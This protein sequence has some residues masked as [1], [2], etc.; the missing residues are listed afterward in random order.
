MSHLLDTDV[1]SAYL[2]GKKQV[3]NRFVQH[4]GGLYISIVS[5]AE[6][7]SWVYIAGDPARREEGLFA[8]LSDVTVLQLDDEIARKCG[9]VRA[10]LRRQGT[11]V[12]TLDM[13]IAGT[14]L[15]NDLTVVTHNQK[16]FHLV[17]KLRIED[18][19]TS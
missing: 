14:A 18:W 1:A 8:M 9:E 10:A 2:Q 7:Y 6:L 12:P 13:L 19:L 17:P 3:F 15:V 11:K 16:H 5:L 4:G